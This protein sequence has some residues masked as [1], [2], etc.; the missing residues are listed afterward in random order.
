[1]L[2]TL[3][4][5]N[6]IFS[7]TQMHSYFFLCASHFSSSCRYTY[8]WFDCDYEGAP[9][10]KGQCQNKRNHRHCRRRF[11]RISFLFFRLCSMFNSFPFNNFNVQFVLSCCCLLKFCCLHFSQENKYAKMLRNKFVAKVQWKSNTFNM[12]FVAQTPKNPTKT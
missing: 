1:M 11:K 4:S 2:Y 6:R 9:G 7:I 5:K 3:F 8:A 12:S 10:L